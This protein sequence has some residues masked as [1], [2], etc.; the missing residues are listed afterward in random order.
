MHPS[1]HP[2][3]HSSIRAL[4]ARFALNLSEL[5]M[6]GAFCHWMCPSAATKLCMRLVPSTSSSRGSEQSKA[7]FRRSTRGW[8]VAGGGWRG[9]GGCRTCA[10]VIQGRGCVSRSRAGGVCGS[11]PR[12]KVFS[13]TE[14]GG[15]RGTGAGTGAQRW[16]RGHGAARDV[17]GWVTCVP[18]APRSDQP[19]RHA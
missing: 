6:P 15:L 13:H 8:R 3:I 17:G 12:F 4:R 5:C 9:T 19:A 10:Y 11:H 14:R 16:W 7:R 2:F 1:I 18:A